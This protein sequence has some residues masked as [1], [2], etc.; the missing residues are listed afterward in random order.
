MKRFIT[1]LLMCLC[2]AAFA[3]AQSLQLSASYLHQGTQTLGGSNQVGFNGGRAEIAY[4]LPQHFL[5]V[6]EFTGAHSTMGSATYDISLITYMAGPRFQIRPKGEKGGPGRMSP[7]AQFL[8]G[9]AHASDGAFPLGGTLVPTA[10]SLAISAGAG[11]DVIL[12][13]RTTL[14][15]L[16]ADYMTT[17][18]PN[19]Y[20]THQNYYRLGAGIV[21]HL[22]K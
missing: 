21:Y 11:M 9:G 5:M 10:N 1:T 14:R 19:L 20:G 8:V 2:C 12:S 7:F 3:R 15:V 18:F 4:G 22:R 13:P 17:Q 16:Q 6:G